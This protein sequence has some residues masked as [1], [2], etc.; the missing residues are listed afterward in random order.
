M[1]AN[2][3]VDRGRLQLSGI[4]NA[5]K[6]LA[7]RCEQEWPTIR[8]ETSSLAERLG[9]HLAGAF[10]VVAYPKRGYEE[11]NGVR[12]PTLGDQAPAECDA[13]LS[14][15]LELALY[16]CNCIASPGSPQFAEQSTKS[17]PIYETMLNVADDVEREAVG[18]TSADL[19]RSLDCDAVTLRKYGNCAGVR[20]PTRGGRNHIFS[21]YDAA[22]ICDAILA[23]STNDILRARARQL[24]KEMRV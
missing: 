17:H 6:N 20:M 4:A 16:L 19:R 18:L 2:Q 15:R 21:A 8:P 10:C 13:V 23:T 3:G 1:S 5:L 9:R 14:D 7:R 12:V 11:I 22:R 24:K